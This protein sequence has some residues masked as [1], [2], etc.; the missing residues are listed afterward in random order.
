MAINFLRLLLHDFKSVFKTPN[1]SRVISCLPVL[2]AA[3]C[4]R[5]RPWAW[6]S[7]ICE[8]SVSGRGLCDE[9]ITRPEETYR[10]WCVVGVIQKPQECVS[11]GPR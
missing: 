2:L 7:V 6:I 1:L 10:L 5:I 3:R 4:V 11:H 9:L 8:C